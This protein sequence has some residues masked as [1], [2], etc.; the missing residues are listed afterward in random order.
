[1]VNEEKYLTI[2]Q[3][4]DLLGLSRV[5]IFKKVKAGVIKA[6]RIGRTWAIPHQEVKS[7]LGKTLT[8]QQKQIVETAVQKT[9]REYGETLKMLGSE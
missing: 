3:I 1:M 6:I 4:A 2:S 5:A 9:I 7:I 8:N